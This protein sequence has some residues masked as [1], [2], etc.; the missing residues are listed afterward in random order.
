MEV[1]LYVFATKK[2]RGMAM[3]VPAGLVEFHASRKSRIGATPPWE[4][5]LP[6]FVTTKERLD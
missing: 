3:I 6:T 2:I 1:L 4:A 5:P